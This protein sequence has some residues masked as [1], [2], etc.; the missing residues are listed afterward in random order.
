MDSALYA[1]D[2]AAPLSANALWRTAAVKKYKNLVQCSPGTPV[3]IL[4]FTNTWTLDTNQ[5]GVYNVGDI[6]SFRF[7][8]NTTSNGTN[9]ITSGTLNSFISSTTTPGN[10]SIFGGNNYSPGVLQVTPNNGSQAA[11]ASICVN[12]TQNSLVLGNQLSSFYSPNYYFDPLSTTFLA[13]YASLYQEYGYVAYPFQLEPFDKVLIQIDAANGFIF[14]YNIAQIAIDGNGNVNILIQ[15][16]IN[17]YFQDAICNG[18]F[19]IIFLKRLRDETSVI[20]NLIKPPGKTSYGFII[21]QNISSDV[22]NNIDNI[23]KNV[24]LQLPDAGSNVIV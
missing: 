19:K 9:K 6:V 22:M 15:E 1:L 14:E 5:V 2:Q 18:F 23:T 20:L 21:P 24:K 12:Q 16:D 7:F 10:K 17:G 13:S 3:S 11:V 4:R 8:C